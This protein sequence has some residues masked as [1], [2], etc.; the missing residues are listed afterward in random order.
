MNIKEEEVEVEPTPTPTP[1]PTPIPG[2]N[3]SI[4]RQ[5][6]ETFE[7]TDD[8]KTAIKVKGMAFI[9]DINAGKDDN[10]RHQLILTNMETSEKIV[11]DGIT[12]SLDS[13]FNL[14]DGYE[15]SK[16]IYEATIDLKLIPV[17]EYTI[18]I[19]VKNGD[20]VKELFLTDTN[21]NNV[22]I[23][24]TAYNKIF[25]FTQKQMYSYR[26][27]L[28]V[29]ENGIDYESIKKPT[30]RDSMIGFKTIE[31]KEDKLILDGV[32]WMYNVNYRES[33][34]PTYKLILLSSDGT[35]ATYPLNVSTC[36]V[37]YTAML[38]SK[39]N[40]NKTCFDANIDLSGLDAGTYLVYL[41]NSSG[42]YKDIFEVYDVGK[43]EI[44]DSKFNN[45]TYS[46]KFNRT[47][48]R[49]SLTISE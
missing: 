23:T 38:K 9:K 32:S 47:R 29:Y 11:I 3:I 49:L 18:R 48:S 17:G 44:K 40:Y 39:F 16:I 13:P 12:S 15:Y 6:L 2:I 24:T 20:T 35:S 28:S 10:V 31:L 30:R 25:K 33:D 34:N 43:P 36:G 26:Y 37:D 42:E 21:I 19:N 4:F 46:L 5:A 45:R 27:E 7:Y 41:E 1:S 8:T 22:P 14:N